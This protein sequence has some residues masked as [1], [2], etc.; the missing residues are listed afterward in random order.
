VQTHWAACLSRY[1]FSLGDGFTHLQNLKFQT[2]ILPETD[3]T[4]KLEYNA[5]KQSV[6]FLYNN[7]NALFSEGKL[8]FAA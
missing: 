7:N 1:A 2:M 6:K 5:D 3:L 8:I 4:L